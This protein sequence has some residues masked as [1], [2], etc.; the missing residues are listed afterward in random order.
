MRTH[1]PPAPVI[2]L[3]GV[4][5]AVTFACAWLAVVRLFPYAPVKIAD[6]WWHLLFDFSPQLLWRFRPY[7]RTIAGMGL[8]LFSAYRQR[9]GGR[10][11]AAWFVAGWYLAAWG[12][13]FGWWVGYNAFSGFP[14]IDSLRSAFTVPLMCDL[15]PTIAVSLPA[16]S[17][18]ILG[19]ITDRANRWMLGG[20]VALQTNL[21]GLMLLLNWWQ[22]Y[23]C[24]DQVDAP[25]MSMVTY[26]V[27]FVPAV[28]FDEED[29][30]MD[31]YLILCGPR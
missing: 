14:R 15:I 21:V 22:L 4:F 26:D 12:A 5:L 17:C 13:S 29:L 25:V 19:R 9:R 1:Q 30:T 10:D 20:W 8:I 28:P 7:W 24:P 11:A 18:G 6:A 31:S 16:L 27:P 23:L 2:T 3:Q